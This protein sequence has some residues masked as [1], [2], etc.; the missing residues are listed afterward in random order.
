MRPRN[1]KMWCVVIGCNGTTG[2]LVQFLIAQ[3]IHGDFPYRKITT[4]GGGGGAYI[5]HC[6]IGFIFQINFLASK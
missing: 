4:L 2:I 5:V 6:A 1:V 3:S